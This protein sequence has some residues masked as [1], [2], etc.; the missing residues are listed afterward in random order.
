MAYWDALKEFATH[1]G[2]GKDALHVYLAFLIQVIAAIVLRRPLSNWMPWA[3]ALLAAM[4]NEVLDIR[5]GREPQVQEW[6][7][8]EA[9][10]D[11]RLPMADPAVGRRDSISGAGAPGA[12]KAVRFN[13]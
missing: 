9:R 13:A 8:V 12:N 7:Q 4:L 10:R 2:V 11:C 3:V 6:Q 5:Y 1:V